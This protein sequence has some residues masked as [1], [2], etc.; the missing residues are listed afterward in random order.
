MR[1]GSVVRLAR[2]AQEGLMT[3]EDLEQIRAAVRGA[4]AP[5][6]TRFDRVDAR[7][8]SVDAKIDS[9]DTKLDQVITEMGRVR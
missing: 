6:E 4:V 1:D 2:L 5:L 3:D 7:F 9:V 8:D